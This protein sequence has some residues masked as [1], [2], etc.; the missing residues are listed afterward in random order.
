MVLSKETG[1]RAR[2]LFLLV[3]LAGLGGGCGDDQDP[4]AARALW[5]RIQ[6]EDYR[7]WARAPGFDTPRPTRAPHQDRVVVYLNATMAEAASG[8]PLDVWP[9]GSL[10]V[11]EGLDAAG[12]IGQVAAMEKRDGKWFWAEWSPEGDSLFS[13]EPTI[14][15]GCH[16]I[17]DDWVRAVFLP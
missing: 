15:L 2:G 12:D 16:R 8:P 10:V 1:S 3:G 6:A 9:E 11:K 7:N 4:A 5:D 13:G 14:C 17:G